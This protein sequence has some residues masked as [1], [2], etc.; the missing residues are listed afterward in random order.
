MKCI[1]WFYLSSSSVTGCQPFR[2]V[3]PRGSLSP[4]RLTFHPAIAIWIVKKRNDPC[5]VTGIAHGKS[6][7]LVATCLPQHLHGVLRLTHTL[8]RTQPIAVLRPGLALHI[9][10]NNIDLTDKRDMFCVDLRTSSDYFPI[11]H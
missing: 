4:H 2:F 10:I 5:C 7:A 11:Q 3:P 9:N 1:R 8:S 6:S